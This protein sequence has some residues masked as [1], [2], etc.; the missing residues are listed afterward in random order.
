ML[1]RFWGEWRRW[2]RIII[3]QYWHVLL[4]LHLGIRGLSRP[5]PPKFSLPK[6][7]LIVH[8]LTPPL[9]WWWVGEVFIFLNEIHHLS[10][11]NFRKNLKIKFLSS[12]PEERKQEE[13]FFHHHPLLLILGAFIIPRSMSRYRL[14]CP[15][16]VQADDLLRWWWRMVGT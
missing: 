4:H 5:T 16:C 1:V 12:L 6:R 13:G 7:P 14:S 3:I 2:K 15:H 9:F 10:G 11:S 8:N